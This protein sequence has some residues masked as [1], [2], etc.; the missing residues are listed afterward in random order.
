VR[1]GKTSERWSEATITPELK[2]LEILGVER[3]WTRIAQE[4]GLSE[5]SLR[6]QIQNVVARRND[7]IHRGDRPTGSPDSDPQSIDYPW[8]HSHIQAIR[9]VVLASD[10][11]VEQQIAALVPSDTLAEEQ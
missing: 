8:T 11:L 2:V 10:E 7:I 1:K 6:Q 9:N 3:P 4:V 5:N